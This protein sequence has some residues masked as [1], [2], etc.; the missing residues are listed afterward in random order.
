MRSPDSLPPNLGGKARQLLELQRAGFTVP[1][2]LCSP[3]DLAEALRTL[4]S[5]VAVRSS[6]SVEDG[7]GHSFAGQFQSF[8]N[9]HT[10]EEVTAAVAQCQ[11]SMRAPSVVEYCRRAGLDPQ[12]L[13]MGYIVQRMVQPELAGVIF[14]VNPTSGAEEVVIEACEGLADELL[15]GRQ[16]ALPSGHPLLRQHRPEIERTARAIQQHFG[17]PQ[18][19]EFAV[20]KGRLYILQARPVTRIH[21][22]PGT[23]EWTNA[24]FRDGGVAAGV[25]TPLMWSLYDFIWEPTLKGFLREIRLLQRDFVAGSMFFGRPYWNLGEVKRCLAQLPGFVEREF[26]LD[27]S[28]QVNYEG[29][30]ISTPSTL[31]GCL[32]ALPTVLR[33]P[34]IWRRQDH[35]NRSFL[36]GGFDQL[37]ARPERIPA[38]VTP[39]FRQLITGAYW[40]TE[41]NYFR[42]IFCVTLAKIAFLEAFP[43]ADFP[44]LVSA[45]PPMTHLDPTRALRELAAGR[46][47]P[48]Q[49][50]QRFGHHSRRELDLR[51]PRWDEDPEWVQSLLNGQT[52]AAGT[53]PKPAYEAAR[54]AAL[55]RLPLHRRGAFAHKLDRLRRFLWQREELRDLSSRI[56][57]KIRRCVLAL[58]KQRGL[59]DD[60][61]FMSW[62][63]ILDDDRSKIR[64]NRERYEGFR[65]FAAP[66]EIGSRF[67]YAPQSSQDAL[68]GVPASPGTARGIARV[69]VSIE[70][71]LQVEKGSILVCPFTDP[72]WTPVLNRVAAVV[73]ETGGL[74]SHAAV[75][76]REYG[77][78]AV[79]GVPHA[80]R[81]IPDGSLVQVHGGAGIVAL[82]TCAPAVDQKLAA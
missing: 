33:I 82:E 71:A 49:F 9:R 15:A 73:T 70:S 18:D 2:F 27:L 59:G 22:A 19:I 16:A 75:I 61:F 43:D 46:M 42:T 24:D 64:A 72:G 25:C 57:H 29:D 51:C 36:A 30:G 68:R 12:T 65:N 23:G 7:V 52:N 62:T 78:P 40:T 38:D 76:C 56:Y 45:L 31:A 8:L 44:A 35:F 58:A 50:L 37:L 39:A 4:G 5:P 3:A 20:E 34:G 48:T 60:I 77:I 41:S 32:R 66:N 53:D 81:R 13:Q 14:T 1:E 26:D 67:A 47:E 54:A 28:V 11:A 74:L 10:L 80:T 6:G 69:A 21:F 17:M 55:A 63:D 79:L